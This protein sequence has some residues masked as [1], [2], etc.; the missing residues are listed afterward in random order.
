MKN[1]NVNIKSEHTQQKIKYSDMAIPRVKAETPRVEKLQRKQHFSP[2]NINGNRK[3]KYGDHHQP[4]KYP[5]RSRTSLGVEYTGIPTPKTH[6]ANHVY[7]LRNNEIKIKYDCNAYA[8]VCNAVYCED[9]GKKL[10]YQQLIKRKNLEDVWKTSFANEFGRL[11]KGVGSRMKSGTE[12]MEP[13]KF[14]NIPADR[15][16]V[17][18][19]NAVDIRPEK[20]ETHRSR[21]VVGGD[22]IEYPDEVYTPTTDMAATK[23]LLNSI[24]STKYAKAMRVD[25]KNYYLN[26]PMGRAGYIF[27]NLADIPDE[28]V[29][30]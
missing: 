30:Q 11:M 3:T 2:K 19:K 29:K 6:T 26:T 17:Y 22:Q 4:H 5:T 21:L 13:V 20:A 8:P 27:I 16:A 24:I 25:I 28:I 18:C 14:Y 23:I 10:S 12:T 15:K 9:T 1:E 7:T